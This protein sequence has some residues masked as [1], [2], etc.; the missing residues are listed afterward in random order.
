MSKERFHLLPLLVSPD[1]WLKK[2]GKI[3]QKC[4]NVFKVCDFCCMKRNWHHFRPYHLVLPFSIDH[5]LQTV[6][7]KEDME[8]Q[9]QQQRT[10]HVFP[11]RVLIHSCFHR[12]HTTK[13]KWQTERKQVLFFWELLVKLKVKIQPVD[14]WPLINN[15][16]VRWN[17]KRRRTH[18]N[19]TCRVDW[20][21][22]NK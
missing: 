4:R 1:I 20:I 7:L 14:L 3:S 22:R 18:W 6:T 9:T 5:K 11:A 8:P 12:K 21:N 17:P 13:S 15:C 16:C 2:E 19:L 10:P